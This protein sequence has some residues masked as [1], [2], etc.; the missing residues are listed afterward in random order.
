MVKHAKIVT[1]LVGLIAL[2]ALVAAGVGVFWQG[3]DPRASFVTQR[4]QTVSIQ[5]SGLYK[6]DSVLSASQGIAQ[7]VVTL[8]MGI[9]LL[10]LSLGLFR[11]NSLRGKLLLA[12][13]LAY[14][15]Y[16][17]LSYAMLMA[18]NSLFL[19]YV[20]LYSLSLFAF[21]FTLRS[22]EVGELP[23]HF[24]NRLP[25]KSIAAFLFLTAAFLLLAWLGRIGPSILGSE[26]PVGL[27]SATTLVIQALDLGLIVPFSFL[28][29]YLL[30]KGNAWGYLIASVLLFKVFTLGTALCAMIVGQLLAGVEIAWIEAVVFPAITLAG[31]I[32]VIVLVRNISEKALVNFVSR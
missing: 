9:P 23:Q 29:G 17:Y 12:G 6:Y 21:I 30:L 2:L 18:Y 7:D 20:A 5:N 1:W 16:T 11:R 8:V 19:L 27:E 31:I 4:G 10:L 25:R 14:F 32:L 26:P 28:G 13:T 15:L 3:S 22:I 24:S